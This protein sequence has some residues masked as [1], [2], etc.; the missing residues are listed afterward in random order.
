MHDKQNKPPSSQVVS[1]DLQKEKGN[2]NKIIV[3]LYLIP[4]EMPLDLPG[5]YN[6]GLISRILVINHSPS[7]F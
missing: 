6:Q 5:K 4:P 3:L 2:D 7:T 1:S